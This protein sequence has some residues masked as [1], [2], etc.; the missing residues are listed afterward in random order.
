MVC[1]GQ[2][3][4]FESF[5]EDDLNI[6]HKHYSVDFPGKNVKKI[7]M[8]EH[9]HH[10]KRLIEEFKKEDT[11]KMTFAK[12]SMWIKQKQCFPLISKLLKLVCV[13]LS[14]TATYE[15]NFLDST[16]LQISCVID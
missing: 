2:F 15:M 16:L 14:S 9:T 6:L 13:I 7:L 3:D 8:N 4:I 11:K 5:N 10:K 12:I 1:L